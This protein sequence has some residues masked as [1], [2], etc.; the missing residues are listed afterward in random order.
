MGTGIT[1]GSSNQMVNIRDIAPTISTLINIS[2]PNG[3]TG[4]PLR[5]E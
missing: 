5:F 3:T 2:F 4:N 1:H